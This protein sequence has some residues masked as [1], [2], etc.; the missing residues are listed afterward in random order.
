MMCLDLT[1]SS[2]EENLALDEALLDA[3]ENAGAGPVLRFY[4]PKDYFVV[5]GYGNRIGTEVNQGFCEANGIPILRRC[6]GG[7]TVLQ[8][9]GVLNYT[10]ILEAQPGSRCANIPGA[11]QFIME[12]NCEAIRSAFALGDVRIEG[13]SDLTF[14]GRKFSGNAQRRRQN[15][16]MFHGSFLLQVDLE[17]IPRAL[18]M[19]SKQPKYREGRSHAEFLTNLNVPA[20]AVKDAMRQVW[21]AT[22]DGEVSVEKILPATMVEKYRSAEWSFKFV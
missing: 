13:C 20:G 9:P 12:R 15:F 1:L 19:P 21:G 18:R 17:M 10:L 3:A 16:L 5:V 7:G 14:G 8:G 22:E 2:P 6:S 11:N 4:E